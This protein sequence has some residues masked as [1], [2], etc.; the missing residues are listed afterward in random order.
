MALCLGCAGAADA[1]DRVTQRQDGKTA[2]REGR[3]EVT[4]QDGGILLLGRDGVLWRIPHEEIVQH[5]H[6]D[7]PFRPFSAE[8][9]SRALKGQLPRG[10][11]VYKTAHYLVFYNTS[12]AYAQW[13]GGLYERLYTAFRSYWKHRGFDLTEPKFPLVAVVFAD[14]PSYVRY[15][16]P[17]LKGAAD[18]IIGYYSLDTNRVA[19]Y[20]LSLTQGAGHRNRLS[21]SAQINQVLTAPDAVRN[22]STIVHEATHQIA[23]NCGLHTRLSDCPRWFSE[24]IAMYFETPDLRSARGWSGIG[25]VSP[26]RVSQFQKYLR[27]RPRDSL[28]TLIVDDKRFQD[29]RDPNTGLDAYAEAWSL[30]Y[31]LLHKYPKQYVEYLRLLSAKKPLIGDTPQERIAQF[32]HYFGDLKQLDG[33]FLRY[34]AKLR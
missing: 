9:M 27:G 34:M 16:T 32:Q 5:T 15:S 26:M 13:C 31:F 12:R 8:E 28:R 20:D 14:K 2:L 25:E 22:V 10:F 30:T 6:D 11:E 24:G 21:T 7:A 1:L 33:E 17:E 4:A 29:L 19:M 23:F 18:S 3:V